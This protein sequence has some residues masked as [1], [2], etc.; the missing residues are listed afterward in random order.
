MNRFW[1][2][3]AISSSAMPSALGI[4]VTARNEEEARDV[5][6]EHFGTSV[7]IS[8]VRQIADMRDIDQRHVAPNIG[9]HF[10]RGV[11]FP[12]LTE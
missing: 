11:W 2:D 9:N 3:V 5:V 6:A 1:I 10:A 8:S 4:G 12:R 7:T